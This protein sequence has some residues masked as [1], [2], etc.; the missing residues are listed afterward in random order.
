MKKILLTNLIKWIMPSIGLLF[1]SS[2]M[3]AQCCDNCPQDLPDGDNAT[4]EVF[5]VD[6]ASTPA[7][8]CL[9]VVDEVSMN[10]THEYIADL[11]INVTSPCGNTAVLVA[12]GNAGSGSGATDDST[13]DITF[14]D[15]VPSPDIGTGTFNVQDSGW[16]TNQNYTGSYNATSG[17]IAG[18][19]CPG[20]NCGT[21]E[22]FV[23]DVT[24]LDSGV[25]NDFGLSSGGSALNCTSV[26]PP[27]SCET[28]LFDFGGA[29]YAQCANIQQSF[30]DACITDPDFCAIFGGGANP[31]GGFPGFSAAD[32]PCTFCSASS[33]AIDFGTQPTQACVDELNALDF[34]T[35]LVPGNAVALD[36]CNLPANAVLAIDCV[37]GANSFENATYSGQGGDGCL[38]VYY[39]WVQR[40][41]VPASGSGCPCENTCYTA[42][43]VT[44]QVPA[45]TPNDNACD[46]SA[47]ALSLE[48]INGTC[49]TAPTVNILADCNG[50]EVTCPTTVE[51]NMAVPTLS[52]PDNPGTGNLL[53]QVTIN[54]PERDA[55]LTAAGVALAPHPCPLAVDVPVSY[56][57]VC[58]SCDQVYEFAA[59]D[60][61]ADNNVTLAIQPGCDPGTLDQFGLE[62]DLDIYLYT[63]TP[64]SAT[65]LGP[66]A[67]YD[68]LPATDNN[69]PTTNPDLSILGGVGGTWNGTI[70]ADFIAPGLTNNTCGPVT[71]TY[72]I[73]PWDRDFDS[74]G[75]G[76][77]GEYNV[78]TDGTC[79]W[80]RV[81][82]TVWPAPFSEV[83]TI[84]VCETTASSIIIRSADGTDCASAAAVAAP[85]DPVCPETSGTDMFMYNFT[86]ADLGL[87]T[88]PAACQQSF[89]NQIDVTCTG[90]CCEILDPITT[91]ST[92]CEGDTSGSLAAAPSDPTC[93]TINWFS[94][95]AGTTQVGT[96]MMYTP[97][98]ATAGTYTYYAQCVDTSIPDCESGLV[99]AVYTINASP[100]VTLDTPSLSC[101]SGPQALNPSPVSGTYSGSGAAFVTGDQIDPADLTVGVTY[102]LTYTFTTSDGCEGSTSITFSF[103]VDCGANGGSF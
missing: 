94:D 15:G 62:L 63:G 92:I 56:D 95:A 86:A 90:V 88:A 91:A 100:T 93:D 43:P 40:F 16:A 3:F 4:F 33:I 42:A 60:V 44:S 12:D 8:E 69:F 10:F 9:D 98:D 49:D 75:D 45:C 22:F 37:N 78:T 7:D 68:P 71:Y 26:A 103:N 82:V 97:A 67:G 34:E 77:F 11:N 73:L 55:S 47:L 35:Y 59:A 96:G 83:P 6:D 57:C 72:F 13:W 17:S 48:V 19:N 61:C 2:S 54:D 80:R 36:G 21:W 64:T 18:L 101:S 81:D 70:C 99:A 50:A 87:D 25:F 66:S 46:P 1:I 79:D 30:D 52:C 14:I 24:N 31:F 74:D 41:N 20:G 28:Q 27:P 29:G 5:V 32:D 51:F 102:D 58:L 89:M 65:D 85:A 53:A 23:D 84:G 76:T 38:P 39:T